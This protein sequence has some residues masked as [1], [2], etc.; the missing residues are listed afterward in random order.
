MWKVKVEGWRMV[1]KFHIC[2]HRSLSDNGILYFIV[3][4]HNK[5]LQ[6]FFMLGHLIKVCPN[7]CLVVMP[8]R[9]KIGGHIVFVLSVILSFRHSVI[10]SFCPPLWNFNLANNFWTVSARALIF[11]MSI[12]CDKTFPWIPLFFTLW[13]W[14]WSLTYFCKTLTLLITFEQWVLELWYFTWVFLVIRPFCWY[15]TFWPWH[16]TYFLNWHWS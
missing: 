14:P 2:I 5:F 3:H 6:L 1:T 11:H 4:N 10:L 7:V 13:P 12:P 15:L 9:S 8:P 16:L